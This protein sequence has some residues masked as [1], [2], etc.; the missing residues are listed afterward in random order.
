MSDDLDLEPVP[1]LPERPPQGEDILWQGA[2]DWRLLAWRAFHVREVAI[3]FAVLIAAQPV[4]ALMQGTPLAATLSPMLWLAL[5]G[6]LAGLI[7]TVLARLSAKATL[8]TVT[9]R[10]VVLRIGVALDMAINL[11]FGLITGADLKLYADGKGDLPLELADG[12]RVSWLLLWPHV[13]PWRISR[14]QPMLR[15]IPEAEMA[16]QVLS[17]ALAAYAGQARP[18]RVT[19]SAPETMALPPGIAAAS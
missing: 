10:R 1:G 3:Y 14:P 19:A 5:A 4:L 2:P 15:A 11:P 7:L 8:Y 17:E 18:A 6:G 9:N 16:G 12:E 13:R